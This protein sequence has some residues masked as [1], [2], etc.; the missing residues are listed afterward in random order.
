MSAIARSGGN[1]RMSNVV[2]H[3]GTL[4][5]AGQVADN[6]EVGIAEQTREV[7]SKIDS[8]LSEHG[9][10]KDRILF[11]QIFIADMRLFKEMNEVWD[12]WVAQG[13]APARATVEARLANPA[14][15]IEICVT[16]AVAEG[17]R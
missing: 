13:N 16:A 12:A 17:A 2:R 6:I 11:C 14:K 10:G 7:L 5:L 8:I 9:S 1:H 4:Y 3:N 15:L